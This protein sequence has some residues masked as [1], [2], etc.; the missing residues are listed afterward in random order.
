M[1]LKLA[2]KEC[3]RDFWMNLIVIVQMAVMLLMG[4]A[5]ITSV[6]SRSAYYE[7]FADWVEHPGSI[8]A[9][10]GG[11]LPITAD[12]LEQQWSDGT[13]A[14][15]TYQLSGGFLDYNVC[16]M[17]DDLLNFNTPKLADGT[18]IIDSDSPYPQAVAARSSG[19]TVGEL[20][21]TSTDADKHI[22][23][24]S[25]LLSDEE[26]LLCYDQ[27][28]ADTQD[29]RFLYNTPDAFE[30]D[31]VK[32]TLLISFTESKKLDCVYYPNGL[33]V[34]SFPDTLT[35]DERAS[36]MIDLSQYGMSFECSNETLKENSLLYIY[37]QLLLLLPVLCGVLILLIISLF[38]VNAVSTVRQLR[39]YA[40]YRICGLTWRQCGYIAAVKAGFVSIA[41]VLLCA[42]FMMLQARLNLLD[43]VLF[44]IQ[45]P[46]VIC[47]SVM[48]LI[49]ILI[50]IVI[51]GAILHRSEPNQLLKSN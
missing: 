51:T 14:A 49:N 39:S 26:L 41:S 16:A 5:G 20:V 34:F 36:H 6:I 47:V 25:G 46:Q 28:L 3:K 40:V 2:L 29:F 9:L 15:M 22:L 42:V 24:I 23:Q 31:G 48:I 17:D 44:R 7:P 45:L 8:A 12:E 33:A 21:E 38:S 4:I 19:L 37:D 11:M 13:S 35:D 18:W 43:S 50:S 1:I 30:I 10:F 32:A 27:L